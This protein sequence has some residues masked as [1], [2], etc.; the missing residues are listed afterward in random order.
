MTNTIVQDDSELADLWT[1]A[2]LGHKLMTDP[3][4]PESDAWVLRALAARVAARASEARDPRSVVYDI[5]KTLG[6]LAEAILGSFAVELAEATDEFEQAH[7]AAVREA[8]DSA[9]QAGQQVDGLAA[10]F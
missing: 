9:Y 1:S 3:D 10:W 5:G 8:I 6:S 2:Q 7:A 4:S